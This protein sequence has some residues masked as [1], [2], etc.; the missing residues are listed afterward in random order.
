[1]VTAT[2]F[3]LVAAVLH[4]GWNL[5]AKVSVDR[6]GTLWAQFVVAGTIA[7]VLLPIVGLPG[8][9]AMPFIV[10]SALVHIG[11]VVL[12]ASGYDH[13]DLS[14]VYPVARG[15]G[16]GGAAI[17]GVVLLHE[18]FGVLAWLGIAVAAAG[19]VSLADRNVPHAVMTRALALAAVIAAYSVIDAAGV[20]RARTGASY[21][22]VEFVITAAVVTAYALV[23]G[24]APSITRV[25][26]VQRGRAAVAGVTLLLTY[27][28]VLLAFRR[29]PTG[30]VTILRE[31]S[32]VLAVLGG[33]RL[34]HERVGPRRLVG[35]GAVFA[36]LTLVVLATG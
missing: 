9:R 4:A 2:V 35:A 7:S 23:R 6:F 8:V 5:A 22:A 18:H 11:Y 33:R 34:L 36:G 17:A 10:A 26:R 14:V 3:A 20:R 13:G 25:W 24:R 28:L 19:I 12:L 21:V 15:A 27:G 29:A 1:V 32:V 16:A 30:F 31:S